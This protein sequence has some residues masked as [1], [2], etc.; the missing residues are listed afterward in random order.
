LTWSAV[1]YTIDALGDLLNRPANGTNPET[2]E[3]QMQGEDVA[4]PDTEV[5]VAPATTLATAWTKMRDNAKVV[6]R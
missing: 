4:R 5:N 2:V 1:G 6:G 3:R